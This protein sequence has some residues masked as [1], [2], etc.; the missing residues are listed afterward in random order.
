MKKITAFL[1]IPI[2][3]GMNTLYSGAATLNE[4][5]AL[6]T[7]HKPGMTILCQSRKVI[8]VDGKT[9]PEIIDE[10]LS[11]YVVSNTGDTMVFDVT[12]QQIIDGNIEPFH[13][14]KYR[15]TTTLENERQKMEVDIRT[16]KIKVPKA[17]HLERTLREVMEAEPVS[18]VD[19]ATHR[20]TTLPAYEILPG[21]DNPGAAIMYCAPDSMDPM[22]AE[23]GHSLQN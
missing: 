14:E 12:Y 18:Y 19:Y 11:G 9:E 21:R 17:R 23:H 4:M 7:S 13:S 15:L 22:P 3:T 8:P 10:K 1:L 5:R 2:L 20:I 16:I 6:N